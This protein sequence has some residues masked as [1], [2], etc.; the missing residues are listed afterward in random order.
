MKGNAP[1]GHY[2]IRYYGKWSATFDIVANDRRNLSDGSTIS[3]PTLTGHPCP[4]NATA[5]IELHDSEDTID[6]ALDN[7]I[8]GFRPCVSALMAHRRTRFQS[9]AR[10]DEKQIYSSFS[11]SSPFR[12]ISNIVAPF[13]YMYV[14]MDQISGTVHLL[15]QF[16]A[17][18][19]EGNE[20]KGFSG[21]CPSAFRER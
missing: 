17:E 9:R 14:S 11:P 15:N 13:L 2:T 5:T 18:R 16:N 7:R 8:C 4:D 12:A 21:L 19:Q 1:Y 6:T 10:R 20:R 3:A